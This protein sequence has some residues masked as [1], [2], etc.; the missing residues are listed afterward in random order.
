[1]ANLASAEIDRIDPA[2][3][4]SPIGLEFGVDPFAIVRGPDGAMWFTENG[5]NRIGRL[6]VDG[7]L[8]EYFLRD[9]SIPTGITVGP[10]GALWFAQRGVSSIG[11]ITVD[12]EITEWPTISTRAA[13]LGITTGSDGA[14]WFTLTSANAIGRIT[15]DGVMTELPLPAPSHTP[16]WITTGPDGA[17]WFTARA[18]NTIGRLTV[19]GGLTEYA[20]PT[21]ASGLNGITAGPDGALWFT[22][23]TA[24]AVGRIEPGGAVSEIPLDEGAAPTGITTGPDGAIWFSASGTNRVGR[25]DAVVEVHDTTAPTI[26]IASPPDG[27]VLT[28][29]EGMLAN[30][31]CEDEPSGSGLTKCEGPVESQEIVPNG[32]GAHTFTVTAEDAAHNVA[33]ASHSYVV[34]AGIGGPI[35][36]QAQFQAGRTL[37]IQLELGSRPSGPLF[38]NGYPRVQAVDCA[39]HDAVG[40]DG[41]A[42]V[43]ATITGSGKLQL[44]WRTSAGWAGTCRSLIVRFG[45][46]GWTDADAVFTLHFA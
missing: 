16:Q 34:F 27:S 37:P 3:T 29:G 41:A 17:L 36:N 2:G 23:G 25:L 35:T 19:G 10:D 38:Q 11:R 14:I 22:E 4:H 30:Y 12:G 39:T 9:H 46:N 20:V 28:V 1:V 13:P 8:S 44:L 26:T 18:T 24:D 32:P 7:E 43:Q 21:A 31:W 40:P 5:G 42:D 6:T 45:L 15:V 33:T